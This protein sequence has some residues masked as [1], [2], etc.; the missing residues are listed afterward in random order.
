MIGSATT[1]LVEPPV[2]FVAATRRYLKGRPNRPYSA[3]DIDSITWLYAEVCRAGN[4]DLRFALSQMAHETAGLTS[5]WSQPPK[6]NPAGIGVTGVAGAGEQFDTW[7]DAVQ[8]HIG[9]ILAYRFP[10]GSGSPSQQRLINMLLV[11][12]PSAPR[13][14]AI[15][16]GELAVRWAADPEYVN[17]L[18]AIEAILEKS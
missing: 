9:L 6:R 18:I 4:V 17:K 11:R 12:R 10:A 1:L 13:G 16:I 8:C 15:T 5:D 2:D 3:E 14:I 7:A